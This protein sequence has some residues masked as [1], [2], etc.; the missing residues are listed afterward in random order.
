MVSSAHPDQNVHG[1]REPRRSARLA[2][3]LI[4]ALIIAAVAGGFAR[5]AQTQPIDMTRALLGRAVV[6]L[7]DHKLTIA[8]KRAELKRMAEANFDFTGMAHATLDGHWSALTPAQRAAFTQ[9]FAGF[10]EDSYLNQIQSYV[11]QSITVLRQNMTDG[12]AD[13]FSTIT[14]PGED[15]IDLELRFARAADGWK[16]YDVAVDEVSITSN[17]R[18]QFDHVLR[19]RGFDTLMADLKAKRRQLEASLANNGGN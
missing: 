4:G 5:A 9:L 1:S 7:R 6:I 12:H 14:S 13:V 10:I 18:T 3:P 15:P 16:I 19:E 8:A 11:G 17:Y 2:A